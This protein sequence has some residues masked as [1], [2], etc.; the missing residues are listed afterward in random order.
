ML[1]MGILPAICSSIYPAGVR[2]S[3]FNLGY[4]LGEQHVLACCL[5]SCGLVSAVQN[6]IH[7][8]ISGPLDSIRS[9]NMSATFN[10]SAFYDKQLVAVAQH[11]D[12]PCSQ[13]DQLALVATSC[14]VFVTLRVTVCVWD[15]GAQ[16]WHAY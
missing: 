4:N 11:D 7:G 13:G 16:S 12:T 9:C 1:Q 15:W 5:Q 3:G 10:V 8:D 14:R 6:S 2:I